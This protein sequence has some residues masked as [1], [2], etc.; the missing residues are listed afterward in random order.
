[1]NFK[2]LIFYILGGFLIVGLGYWLFIYSP[3]QETP[4]ECPPCDCEE[5][6]PYECPICLSD[7]KECPICEPEIIT[8]EVIKEVEKIVEVEVK[9][10]IEVPVE[11]IKEVIIEKIV[12]QDRI[13]YRDFPTE[14]IYDDIEFRESGDNT[15][16]IKNKSDNT[17]VM[18]NFWLKILNV[19]NKDEVTGMY[20]EINF[21]YSDDSSWKYRLGRNINTRRLNTDFEW[22]IVLDMS[23]KCLS[24]ESLCRR[25]EGITTLINQ[26]RPQE[27]VSLRLVNGAGATLSSCVE[28]ILLYSSYS[29]IIVPD[30]LH[31]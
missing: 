25:N 16:T 18:R 28:L 27:T 8:K 26:I 19:W 21:P 3:T 30:D 6:L 15:F 14:V 17:I 9:K 5:C 20:F 31:F 22:Q 10:I 7:E 1:M 24:N 12:Y 23:E 29:N 2:T 4:L 11:V 13:V